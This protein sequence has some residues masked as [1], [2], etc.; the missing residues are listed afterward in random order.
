MTQPAVDI[1][2]IGLGIMGR[3]MVRNLVAAG[4]RVTAWNRT[5]RALP[6]QLAGLPLAATIAEAVA[7]KPFVM[8]CLTGPDAQRATLTAPGG[9][10]ESAAPGTLIA[11]ATT[12]DPH[13]TAELAA[14]AAARG[15]IYFDTPVFGSKG[16]AWDGRLDFVCGGDEARF[17]EI[18]PI[19]ATM[20]A[21]VHRLGPSPAGASM[22]LVGNLLVAAQMASLG[23]AL[24]M[25]RKAGLAPDAVMSVLDVT[26]FSSALIRG[27]GRASFA[28]DFAPSFY[29]EHMLKDARLIGAY[30]RSLAVPTP[31]SAVIGELYQAAM[32]RGLGKLNASALHRMMFEMSGLA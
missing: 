13:L 6:P 5:A 2:F 22:K 9:V 26:D 28:G 19:L 14:A 31:N 15:L 16:E 20:A 3:G 30:A 1:G 32:N 10:F 23:E 17:E 29:L 4:H 7:G 25:A 8:I 11:D 21:T 18:R 24:S 12:T 27:V